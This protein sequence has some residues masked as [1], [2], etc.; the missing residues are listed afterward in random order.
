MTVEWV[1]RQMTL[2]G[3]LGS[4]ALRRLIRCRWPS[5]PGTRFHCRAEQIIDESCP[6]YEDR[7]LCVQV[8][9][10]F[11]VPRER[12]ETDVCVELLDITDGA[13]QA[14]Q[15]LS[16]APQWQRP[17]S[18]VFYYRA[19][20]GAVAGK[21]FV[22]SKPITIAKIPLHLLRFA[23]RGRRKIQVLAGMI[24]REK[25]QILARADTCMEY[26]A[27]GEGYAEIQER[28]EAVL[29]ACV[30][31]ACAVATD[32][33]FIPSV[34]EVIGD[35]IADK[36]RRFTPRSDLLEPLS[37]LEASK[38]TFDTA[39]ACEGIL[40]WGQKADTIEAMDL[41]LQVAALYASPSARQEQLLWELSDGLEL[42]QERFIA[43]CQKQLLTD[44]CSIERWRL[45][46]G[47]RREL[48]PEQLRRLIN[49]EYRKWNARITHA[50]PR[51]RHQADIILS[52]I[53]D[54]R[55]RQQAVSCS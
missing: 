54:V 48:A 26:V 5:L 1:G 33:P 38:G 43:L 36:T 42:S 20:Y 14:E 18:P 39:G 35:W 32:E 29:R 24:D 3:R 7:F 4:A 51:I 40:A 44:N 37:R 25:G 55:S 30:E 12:S 17:D 2:A 9:G 8:F 31:L 21:R 27:C 13:G 34:A 23:R 49:E 41:A 6:P 45:L 52:I 53:A 50:D 28:R 19:H 10:R 46:L 15:V 16:A 47:V 11:V 22:L